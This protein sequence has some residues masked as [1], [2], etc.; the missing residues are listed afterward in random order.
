M[1]AGVVLT[2]LVVTLVDVA[3]D[4]VL[5]VVPATLPEVELPG[6]DMMVVMDKITSE[7]AVVAA[8]AVPE[9]VVI[10]AQ[11]KMVVLVV[12]EYHLV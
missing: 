4:L 7:P 11:V 9:V 3:A 5:K 6:K 12:L 10:M 8:A 2:T 1:V